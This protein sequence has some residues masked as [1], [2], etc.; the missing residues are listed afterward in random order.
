VLSGRDPSATASE[1]D[2]YNPSIAYQVVGNGPRDESLK[3][4]VTELANDPS[5]VAMR[6]VNEAEVIEATQKRAAERL[7]G[8][9][10]LPRRK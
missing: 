7:A 2:S 9:P 3:E 5:A 1:T 4:I 10:P 8:I 6:G